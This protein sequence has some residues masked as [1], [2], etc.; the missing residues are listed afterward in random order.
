M[1]R[2]QD[3]GSFVQEVVGSGTVHG[4][5]FLRLDYLHYLLLIPNKQSH[6]TGAVFIPISQTR[7]LRLL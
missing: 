5:L 1:H 3:T 4:F 7:K 6:V 2:G